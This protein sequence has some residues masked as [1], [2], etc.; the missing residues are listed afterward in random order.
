[1]KHIKF[2][3]TLCGVDFLLNVLHSTEVDRS[4]KTG[5]AHSADFFQVIWV[6]KAE[7]HL[8]LNEQKL[9]L[10]DNSV[11]FI[12]QDQKYQWRAKPRTL[13]AMILVFQED[14]LNEFF[15]DSYFTYRLHYFYQANHP[16][17]L[18]L[19]AGEFAEYQSKLSEVKR[20]IKTP[21]SDSVH[22]IRSILYYVLIQLNRSYAEQH[23]INSAISQDNLAYHFRKLVET[24]LRHKQRI[25][26][27][28][29]LLQVSRITL[30]KV[31]KQHFNL[32]ATDFI[33]SRLLFELKMQLIYSH[34][35]IKEIA[36]E[37]HFSEPNHLSRF[38]KRMQGKSPSEFRVDY[39]NG[40]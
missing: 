24:H 6:K 9:E 27:Y 32:S 28:T 18:Q 39:Q 20:E 16:L 14:F 38:F 19:S 31:V 36:H 22:L 15:S 21:K 11:L 25:E 33:K 3:K 26:D 2:N 5:E 29:D 7:G 12:S 30:N 13:D 1:M 4:N 8:F 37:F 23:N 40:S 10:S 17:N 34:K 35:S